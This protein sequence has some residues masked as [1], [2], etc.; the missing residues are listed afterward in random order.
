VAEERKTK[1]HFAQNWVHIAA[2]AL[3]GVALA[4]IA[5]GNSDKPLLPSFLTNVLTQQADFIL[6][7][8][9]AFLLLFVS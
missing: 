2:I 5:T 6:I 4:D 7:A 8:A 1:I 3:I 9:G